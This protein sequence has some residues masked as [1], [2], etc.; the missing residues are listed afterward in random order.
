MNAFFEMIDRLNE[1]FEAQ[2]GEMERRILVSYQ[3]EKAVLALDMSGF[4]LSV[5]RNGILSCLARIRRMQQLTAPLLHSM[6]QAR[7]LSRHELARQCGV[8]PR[9]IYDLERGKPS[10]HFGKIHAVLLNLGLMAVILDA[11]MV[12]MALAA[13][14]G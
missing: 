8:G 3:Q 14:S 1:S 13:Q 12:R 7:G 9:F 4:S 6:R 2:R 10:L 5:R 11:Q